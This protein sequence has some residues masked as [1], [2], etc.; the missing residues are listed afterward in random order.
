MGGLGGTF[1]KLTEH[2]LQMEPGPGRVEDIVLCAQHQTVALFQAKGIRVDVE[3]CPGVAGRRGG[4]G[5]K[6]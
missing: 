1:E 2:K 3:V 4:R 6:G 5:E